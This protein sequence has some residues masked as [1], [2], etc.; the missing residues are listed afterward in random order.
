MLGLRACPQALT[1]ASYSLTTE[2]LRV[3]RETFLHLSHHALDFPKG[4]EALRVSMEM[5]II[6][7]K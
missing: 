6:I 7:T 1:P 5:L 4:F 2:K 3:G